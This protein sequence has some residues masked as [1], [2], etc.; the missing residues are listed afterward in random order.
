M[1]YLVHIIE[2]PVWAYAGTCVVF[3]IAGLAAR[4]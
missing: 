4:R 2:I 1:N 3:F